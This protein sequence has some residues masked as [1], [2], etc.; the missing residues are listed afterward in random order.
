[1]DVVDLIEHDHR[2]IEE[3]FAKFDSTGEPAVA[4][5]LCRELGRHTIAEASVVYPVVARELPN[6]KQMA[7]EGEDEHA[8]ATGLV[9]RIRDAETPDRMLGLMR[10]LQASVELHVDIEESEVLPLMRVVLE[11]DQL[12]DLGQAYA[13]AKGEDQPCETGA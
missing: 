10:E 9:R 13:V 8:E 7:G 2:D 12:R 3:L 4:H 5:Q 6:G 11:A 1:M